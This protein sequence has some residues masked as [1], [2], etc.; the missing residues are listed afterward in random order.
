MPSPEDITGKL[1]QLRNKKL[2]SMVPSTAEA[3]KIKLR[4]RAMAFDPFFFGVWI[5]TLSAVAAQFVL[6]VVLNK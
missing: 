1:D 2:P 4:P 6:P 3:K 5:L